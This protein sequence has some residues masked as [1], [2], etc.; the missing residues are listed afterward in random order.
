MNNNSPVVSILEKNKGKIFLPHE[1]DEK[2]AESISS[3]QILRTL[4][5][6][7][8]KGSILKLYV[9]LKIDGR[10]EKSNAFTYPVGC[11]D[12][13]DS[14]P[15]SPCF[16]AWCPHEGCV[17]EDIKPRS[18]YSGMKIVKHKTIRNEEDNSFERFM[19]EGY[20]IDVKGRA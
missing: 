13:S 10:T 15:N 11:S 6:E 7:A 3:I 5:D 19:K 12:Y 20:G 9:E 16:E 4:E 14:T 17:R 2:L 18:T 1:I 8:K